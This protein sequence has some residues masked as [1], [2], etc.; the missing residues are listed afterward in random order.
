[1]RALFV[2]VPEPRSQRLPGFVRRLE[3]VKLEALLFNRS[4]QT[5]NHAVLLRGMGSNELLFQIVSVQSVQKNNLR[6]KRH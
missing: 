5:F 4:N 1:M 6:S 3:V 2:V